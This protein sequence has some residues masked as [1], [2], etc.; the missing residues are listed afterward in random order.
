MFLYRIYTGEVLCYEYTVKKGGKS[1]END[2]SDNN[3]NSDMTYSYVADLRP[4]L[5]YRV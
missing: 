1:V 3:S 2:S 5:R 4:M